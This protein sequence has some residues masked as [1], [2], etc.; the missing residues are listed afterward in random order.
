M[1][2]IIKNLLLLLLIAIPGFAREKPNILWLVGENFSMDL[3]CYGQE[4]VRTT[5]LDRL[6]REGVR[7]TR[8]YSTSPVCAPSRSA[9]MTGW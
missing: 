7:Y 5:N 2:Q 9:F 4:N 6:A 1:K 3:A 8:V